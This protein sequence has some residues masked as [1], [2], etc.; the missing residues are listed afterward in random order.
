MPAGGLSNVY[1]AREREREREREMTERCSVMSCTT[2]AIYMQSHS[3]GQLWQ[4]TTAS[5]SI[6]PEMAREWRTNAIKWQVAR[7][8]ERER[9]DFLPNWVAPVWQNEIIYL[10]GR[11]KK[12]I[13]GTRK[14]LQQQPSPVSTDADGVMV[15]LIELDDAS[16]NDR[17]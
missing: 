15:H 16:H 17:V 11:P 14:K 13:L 6:W 12:C 9:G 1:Y 5:A 4:F 2:R 8:R 10:P 3:R 7:E